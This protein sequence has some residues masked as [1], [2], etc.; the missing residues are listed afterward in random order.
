MNSFH[1]PP[2]CVGMCDINRHGV[3]LNSPRLA[4]AVEMV[5][6]IDFWSQECS[7]LDQPNYPDTGNYV[8]AII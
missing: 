6:T 7:D 1:A 8:G 3:P 5:E 4:L 2:S